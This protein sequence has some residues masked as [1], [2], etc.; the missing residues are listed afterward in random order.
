LQGEIA[1]EHTL[2]ET[3]WLQQTA[4]QRGFPHAIVAYAPLQD[5]N[6]QNVLEQH[7]QYQNVRGIRQILNPDQCERADYLTDAQWQAGYAHLKRFGMSFDLQCDPAQMS[8]AARLAE[9]HP[10]IALIVNHTGMPR[11]QSADGLALWR[12]GLRA[13]AA[14]PHVS[15]KISG[16]AMFG[17]WTVDSIRPYV[18]DAMEIFGLERSMFASNFPVD[19]ASRSW[20]DI[21][22]AFDTLTSDLGEAERAA[23]FATNAERIYRI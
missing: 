18:R 11:D 14:L 17:A 8:D 19:R 23:L 5:P 3:I 15:I 13:L 1:R 21:F 10:D 22:G 4:D 9:R 16:F 7:A 12:S 6:V 2:D 20:D